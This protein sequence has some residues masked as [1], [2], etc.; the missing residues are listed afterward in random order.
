M[1]FSVK[2][3]YRVNRRILIWIIFIAV[4]FMLREF[5]G[6][7]FL[8]FALS[9]IGSGLS[10]Q[11][12]RWL[13]MPRRAAVFAVFGL[14][15]VAIISALLFVVPTV[16]QEVNTLLGNLGE[17]QAKITLFKDRVAE[18]YPALKRVIPGTIRGALSDERRLEV[19][20][21]L[22]DAREELALTDQE[23]FRA[24]DLLPEDPGLAARTEAYL[25]K[26]DDLLFRAFNAE[27]AERIR[28]P[29]LHGVA[30]LGQ[31][32]AT[33]L[34]ALLFAF[35]I[36]L[37]LVRIGRELATLRQSRLHHFYEQTAQPVVRFGYVVG[38][39]IQAQAMIAVVNTL[40]TFFGMLLLDI[41]LL[42]ALTLIV[43]LCSF[44]PVLG[45]WISTTPIFIVALNTHGADA[46]L[47]VV[48]MVVILHALE[49][50][51]LNPLIYGA[52]LKL[53]PVLVLVILFVG[54]NLFGVWG[55]LL[56]I[57]VARYF[58]HDVFGMP[59]LG[60]RGDKTKYKPAPEPA[61]PE[62]HADAPESTR[63]EP[64]RAA[65]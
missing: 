17:T 10:E 42:A 61:E 9:F 5:F 41:P 13:R 21:E 64:D 12:Q 16:V 37:D 36:T 33:L 60:E 18:D 62:N 35:L 59:A 46:A 30:V 7:V 58:M 45:V 14:F 6:I 31:G 50:Y 49:A 63:G 48:V 28:G 38:R 29:A 57:P 40:L 4:L 8:T 24:R 55:T 25:G 19:D 51:V 52:H 11:A 15:L 22:A 3:F 44:I 56:G 27:Q 53:N 65:Q 23:I 26:E 43:F 47:L 34:L 2:Q 20:K 39:A 54:Y 1:S 32:T